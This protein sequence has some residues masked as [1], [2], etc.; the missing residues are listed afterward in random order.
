MNTDLI[1]GGVAINAQ[2]LHT[3]VSWLSSGNCLPVGAEDF[4]VLIS[5]L[6][7]FWSHF[8]GLARFCE[9]IIDY[10]ANAENAPYPDIT[11]DRFHGE[12][13]SA[14]DILFTV[15]I[16]ANEPKVPTTV[17]TYNIG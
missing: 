2:P 9:S 1:Q 13:S 11:V 15:W 10:V 12:I 8:L 16:K 14:Y 7:T 5:L 6:R 3:P 17:C 4:F